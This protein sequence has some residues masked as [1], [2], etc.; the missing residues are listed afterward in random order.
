MILHFLYVLFIFNN[1]S[2]YFTHNTYSYIDLNKSK[3]I[4]YIK[5]DNK[6]VSINDSYQKVL[7]EPNL[8]YDKRKD[9]NKTNRR[10]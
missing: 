8:N 9:T 3:N 2:S 1:N 6:S 10:S 4:S 7:T 5:K